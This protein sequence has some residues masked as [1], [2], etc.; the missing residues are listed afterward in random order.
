MIAGS[1]IFPDSAA[2]KQSKYMPSVNLSVTDFFHISFTARKSKVIT[3]I[4][5]PQNI[6]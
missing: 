6:C 4:P 1:G 5:T 3:P 2:N